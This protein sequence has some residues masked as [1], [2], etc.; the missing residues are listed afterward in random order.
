M[1]LI[2]RLLSGIH[3]IQCHRST[4]SCHN[5]LHTTSERQ[6]Q[7]THFT[8]CGDR[9]GLCVL[10]HCLCTASTK[11]KNGNGDRSPKISPAKIGGLTLSRCK[12]EGESLA[13]EHRSVFRLHQSVQI[14]VSIMRRPELAEIEKVKLTPVRYCSRP[15]AVDLIS[16]PMAV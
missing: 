4:R 9:R 1:Y 2:R 8:A 3:L 7:F 16:R 14:S 15:T 10:S 12:D 6:T 5:I 13:D 11:S